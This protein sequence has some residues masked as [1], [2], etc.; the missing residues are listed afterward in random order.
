M[1]DKAKIQNELAKEYALRFGPMEE[2]RNKVWEIL[3]ADFFQNYVQST[4]SVLDLGCGWGEFINNIR[5]EKKYGMDLNPDAPQYLN[6]DVTFINQDC[7]Q[8]WDVEPSSLDIIFTS[9][10]FEHL[11]TKESLSD[12]LAQAHQ[13]LKP[14][15]KIICLGP[16]I[17]FTGQ[18][19]WDFFD[20][21]I[22]LTDLSLV[23]IL[24]IQN[25]QITQVEPRFLPYTMVDKK[26]A[27][28]SFVK[29]YLKLKV[30]WRLYGQQFLV[31]ATK[32]C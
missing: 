3:T 19:Y 6:N 32:V 21:H 31:V 17:R 26:P 29:L 20:H 10:F 25:F 15:G 4:D 5:C 12:T 2:Y 22:A 24:K 23:E 14:D 18:R 8:P 27:P 9:N 13:A 1:N 16:N 30:A 7:S 11:L 28:L